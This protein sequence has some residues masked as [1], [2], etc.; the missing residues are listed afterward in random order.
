M[1]K[2]NLITQDVV[3]TKMMES[4]K[5]ELAKLLSTQNEQHQQEKA[6]LAVNSWGVI[7]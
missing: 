5:E 3:E 1:L 4:L 6:Q 2:L 7:H